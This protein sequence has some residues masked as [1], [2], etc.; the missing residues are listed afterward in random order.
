MQ[1]YEFLLE[2]EGRR[3]RGRSPSQIQEE[4]T[5]E[6]MAVVAEEDRGVAPRV[7]RQLFAEVDR[8]PVFEVED[9]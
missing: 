2:S 6:V 1:A 4:L 7:L 8:N 5:R 9:R 3:K